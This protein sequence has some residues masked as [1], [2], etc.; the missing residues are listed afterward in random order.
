VSTPSAIP[1]PT[2]SAE[3][4][5]EEAVNFII[6]AGTNV[7]GVGA[8]SPFTVTAYPAYLSRTRA[9]SP[10]DATRQADWVS[11]D[12]S[13]ATI[14]SGGLV[15]AR[16]AGA[17][18]ISASYKG[19]SYSLPLLVVDS[20][21]SQSLSRYAGAWSGDGEFTCERLSGFGRIECDPSPFSTQ[22]P[23]R[24]PIELTLTVAGNMLA[25]TLRLYQNPLTVPVQAALLDARQLTIGGT[26]GGGSEHALIVQLRDWRLSL[27]RDGRLVGALIE[28]R[29]FVNVYSP[30][31][32][33][34]RLEVD[35]LARLGE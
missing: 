21:A 27:T 29:A 1:S 35:G 5:A 8:T 15:T 3:P 2:P 24:H 6:V 26:H 30:Q 18:D 34:E 25:G 22:W 33:R 17:T 23:L 13:V 11:S 20:G 10:F 7:V 32:L 14:A 16:S 28:D 4:P 12:P 19:K 31:L 9:Y